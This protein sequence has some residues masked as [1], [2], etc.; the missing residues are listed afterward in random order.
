MLRGELMKG[1]GQMLGGELMVLVEG[2]EGPPWELEQ[3]N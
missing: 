3:H 2:V 1:E